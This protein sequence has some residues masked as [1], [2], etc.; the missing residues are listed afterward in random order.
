MSN[1]SKGTDGK[2]YTIYREVVFVNVAIF[3]CLSTLNA[4]SSPCFRKKNHFLVF[5]LPSSDRVGWSSLGSKKKNKERMGWS[6]GLYR[7]KRKKKK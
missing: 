7:K 1:N 4:H 6:V 3:P 2:S 5:S